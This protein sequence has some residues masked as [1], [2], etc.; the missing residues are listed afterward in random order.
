[1]VYHS[2][3]ERQRMVPETAGIKETPI[4]EKSGIR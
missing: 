4:P 2:Y 1:M 3:L